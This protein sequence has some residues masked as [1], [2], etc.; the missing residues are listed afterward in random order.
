[1]ACLIS[2]IGFDEKFLVRSFLRRGRQQVD[3]VLVVKPSTENEKTEKAI[4][5]LRRLLDEAHVS[6]EVL[7]VDH[8]NFPIAVSN[9]MTW[10]RKSSYVD[11]ILNL[12]SGM[13][14]VNI[15]ILTAFLLLRLD[16]EVEVEPESLQDVV[17]FRVSDM[18]GYA[19]DST[20]LK[21][22]SAIQKGE[23]KIALISKKLKIPN[24]TVW[25]RV[26][27]LEK[28]GFL[29][30]S[31]DRLVLKNKGIIFLNFSRNSQL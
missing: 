19:V 30:S 4:S 3:Y 16:A 25:R 22:L 20:D 7:Q 10:L 14:L 17:S 12:S 21:I 24:A 13:R 18:M 5:S 28:N 15:E 27:E 11:Y 23:N 2:S 29:S 1:M 31:D 6:L 8:M 26:K 9:V